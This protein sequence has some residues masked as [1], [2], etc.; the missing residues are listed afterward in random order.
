M[1]YRH[2]QLRVLTVALSSVS[3]FLQQAISFNHFC[4]HAQIMSQ[5]NDL[6]NFMSL[7]CAFGWLQRYYRGEF[8]AVMEI[9]AEDQD[10]RLPLDWAILVEDWDHTYWI[11][12]ISLLWMLWIRDGDDFNA[13]HPALYGWLKV[14]DE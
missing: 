9:I 2:G 8:N 4:P 1:T 10:E 5:T 14:L 11:V 6:V 7:E 3:G 13:A 12:W